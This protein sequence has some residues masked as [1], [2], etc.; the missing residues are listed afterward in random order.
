[1]NTTTHELARI[2]RGGY[3][4]TAHATIDEDI[5]IVTQW[6]RCTEDGKAMADEMHGDDCWSI[7]QR[8]AMDT[9]LSYQLL[10]QAE[11]LETASITI[12]KLTMLAQDTPFGKEYQHQK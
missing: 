12:D 11:L 5:N 9:G 10:I 7:A 6:T 2:N 8:C 4:F 1:M 3:T